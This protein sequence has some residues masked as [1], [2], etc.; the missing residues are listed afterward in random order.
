MEDDN[1][2]DDILGEIESK[3]I[4]E[5]KEPQGS[6][7]KISDVLNTTFEQ[8]MAVANK[9]LEIIAAKKTIVAKKE[10]EGAIVL[11]D[12]EEIKNGLRSVISNLEQ[13]MQK[14]QDDIK[15][16][17]KVF[18]HQVYSQCAEVLMNSYAQL[19]E[20]NKTIFDCRLKAQAMQDKAN[21]GTGA[22][23]SNESLTLTHEQMLSM[24]DKARKSSSMNAVD[25]NFKVVE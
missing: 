17:S 16:V 3:G 13:V 23:D 25:A 5:S 19:A 1:D 11:D 2:I 4:K 20:I 7:E 15:I 18:S 21:K 14:L 6:M 8:D 10:A 24:I 9:Q 22:G 12:Q